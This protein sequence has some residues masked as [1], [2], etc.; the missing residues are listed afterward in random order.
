MPKLPKRYLTPTQIVA[1]ADRA[2]VESGSWKC[3]HSPTGAHHWVGT[4]GV[5]KCQYCPRTQTAYLLDGDTT[6]WALTHILYQNYPSHK[7]GGAL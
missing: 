1:K 7:S 2:Y 6:P 4:D 3:P 5:L